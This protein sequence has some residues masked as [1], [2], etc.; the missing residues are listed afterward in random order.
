MKK[1][2]IIGAGKIVPYHIDALRESGFSI[3]AISA[4]PGSKH[5]Q[6]L[7][8][9]YKIPRVFNDTLQ[10]VHSD[11]DAILIAVSQESLLSVLEQALPSNKKILIEKPVF[12]GT[13][14]FVMNHRFIDNVMVAYNRRFY[15]TVEILQNRISNSQ[16]G[17]FYFYI[18]ELSS[19]PNPTEKNILNTLRGN[20]V[21]YL[22]LISFIFKSKMPRLQVLDTGSVFQHFS[23]FVFIDCGSIKGIL[24]ITFGSPGNY[25]LE[26]HNGSILS[27][28]S[29]IETY[30]EFDSMM[31]QEPDDTN[32]I[33]RYSPVNSVSNFS[34]ISEDI[35]FKPGFLG[36]SREFYNFV[37][38]QA[39]VKGATLNDASKVANLS[40]L[41]ANSL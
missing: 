23:K 6:M 34:L 33:R 31:V 38:G 29:P 4:T 2:G 36:Q 30:R 26:F 5:A 28:L 40:E 7:A 12:V 25:R 11:I 24:H 19:S 9:E 1:I 20:T 17:S 13:N 15:S 18:P 41:I 39:L 32:P 37:N 35:Q 3:S 8:R 14:Q 16:F 22:D 21:H 10:L 27:L